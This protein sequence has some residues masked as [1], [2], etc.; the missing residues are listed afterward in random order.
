NRSRAP[1]SA[2]PASVFTSFRRRASFR[3]LGGGRRAVSGSA[4]DLVGGT[5]GGAE[6]G[7][8]AVPRAGG[9]D[10]A[11]G[12]GGGGVDARL[13]VELGGGGVGVVAR[14]ELHH[15]RGVHDRSFPRRVG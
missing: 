6:A 3:W 9:G 12:R 8:D 10:G 15:R 14:D 1:G 13:E 5:G 11:D 2:S 7:A 4:A